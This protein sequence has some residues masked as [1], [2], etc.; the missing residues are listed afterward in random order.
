MGK[1]GPGL[2]FDFRWK[3]PGV[4]KYIPGVKLKKYTYTLI[5]FNTVPPPQV[6]AY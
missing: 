3:I 2:I 6:L 5:H 1:N 4:L